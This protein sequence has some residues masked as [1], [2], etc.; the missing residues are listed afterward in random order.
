M[1]RFKLTRVITLEDIHYPYNIP[2]D[3]VEE[4]MFDWKPHVI[5][6]AG[7]LLD[8]PDFSKFNKNYVQRARARLFR[9]YEEVK[10]ILI[11]HKEISGAKRIFYLEGNHERRIREYLKEHP[12]VEGLIEVPK[13]LG[14]KELGI[15]W[16]EEN[17]MIQIG[18]LWYMHG[19]F[20]GIYHAKQTL[21]AYKR[22]IRYGHTHDRQTMSDTR[23][24]DIPYSITAKSICCLC[25]KDPEFNR[26][27]PNRWTNG[28]HIAEINEDGD[29]FWDYVIEMNNGMFKIPGFK[30]I[31]GY[32]LNK[33][34]TNKCKTKRCICGKF[35]SGNTSECIHC[36]ALNEFRRRQ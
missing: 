27:R 14:L 36:T 22:N 13:G 15:E 24:Y 30:K 16:I 12:E 21:L 11:K 4:F 10:K 1:K 18:N 9:E 32:E 20:H 7:D 34:I 17:K 8:L 26:K 19:T 33:Q 6:Y 29:E 5:I 35:I 3:S 2:L 28:F 31:Y 25:T 23:P